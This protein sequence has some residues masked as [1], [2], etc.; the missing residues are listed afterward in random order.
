MSQPSPITSGMQRLW[1]ESTPAVR[2][3]ALANIVIFGIPALAD[4][5]G[6]RLL[7]ISLSD[8]LL[9]WVPRTISPLP[10]AISIIAF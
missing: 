2:L 10:P 7:G 9:M 8:L 5:V 3:I 4:F 6:F 1:G